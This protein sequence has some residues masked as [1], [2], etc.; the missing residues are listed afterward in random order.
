MFSGF[1]KAGHRIQQI[2]N[3]LVVYIFWTYKTGHWILPIWNILTKY[4]FWTYKNWIR[5]MW[6]LLKKYISWIYKSKTLNLRNVK[7]VEKIY[8]L[9]IQK[10]DTKLDKYEICWRNIFSGRTKAGLCLHICR[11]SKKRIIAQNELIT[12]SWYHKTG[13]IYSDM[14]MVTTHSASHLR[15]K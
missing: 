5:D 9:N 4:I 3:R 1:T 14:L 13:R 6:N 12:P 15:F 10:Q 11:L 2:W 7:S 8:L